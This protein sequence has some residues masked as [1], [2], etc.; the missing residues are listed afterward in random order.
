MLSFSFFL[1]VYKLL[2]LALSGQF[3]GHQRCCRAAGLWD[4]CVR[5]FRLAALTLAS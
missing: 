3:T 1:Q 4:V 5:Y 2:H